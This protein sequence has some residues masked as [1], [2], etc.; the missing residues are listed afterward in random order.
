MYLDLSNL[1]DLTKEKLMEITEGPLTVQSEQEI[2][3]TEVYFSKL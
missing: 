1:C 3:R 2:S